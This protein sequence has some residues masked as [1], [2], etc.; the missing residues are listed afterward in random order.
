MHQFLV[1]QFQQ[2]DLAGL[3]GKLSG[4][5]SKLLALRFE[6]AQHGLHPG[7]KRRVDILAG[8]FGKQIHADIVTKNRAESLMNK[9][10]TAGL[11]L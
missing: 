1:L 4:A 9:G 8:K 10:L 6:L 3:L 7:D 2:L 5:C 11:D